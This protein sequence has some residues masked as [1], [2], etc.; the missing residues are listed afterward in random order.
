MFDEGKYEGSTMGN[1]NDGP[2]N[3]DSTGSTVQ[4][5]G[6]SACIALVSAMAEFEVACTTAY[7]YNLQFY[8]T[9]HIPCVGVQQIDTKAGKGT[10]AY[11]RTKGTTSVTT[12][13]RKVQFF[14]VHS[15]TGNLTIHSCTLCT[16]TTSQPVVGSCIISTGVVCLGQA[17]LIMR[18]SSVCS[19]PFGCSATADGDGKIGIGVYGGSKSHISFIDTHI[20][21]CSAGGIV[22]SG[23]VKLWLSG[24]SVTHCKSGIYA[25]NHCT[26]RCG[27]LGIDTN[28]EGNSGVSS[29]TTCPHR[30]ESACQLSNHR[31]CGLEAFGESVVELAGCY[32]S[33]NAGGGILISGL[34]SSVNL[35]LQCMV[36]CN[37]LAN[38]T[39]SDSAVCHLVDHSCMLS[40]GAASGVFVNGQHS[41]LSLPVAL[42]SSM[43]CLDGGLGQQPVTSAQVVECGIHSNALYDVECD[44]HF[45][46]DARMQRN[47]IDHRVVFE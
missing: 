2:E 31:R 14:R 12:A 35:S 3:R 40:H 38:V 19:K 10:K 47:L 36:V 45:T 6:R 22:V 21:H 5:A 29:N 4:G 46:D 39:I 15:S 34:G 11:T 8:R 28:S 13:D 16:R 17:T 37:Q 24:C 9:S 32:V 18:N 27:T 26:I 41:V 1:T 42:L 44:G 7:L 23:G 43:S 25:S 20:S 30:L 33:H